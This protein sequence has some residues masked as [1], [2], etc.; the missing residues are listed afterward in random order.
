MSDEEMLDVALN[1][2]SEWDRLHE[3]CRDHTRA[4]ALA[5]LLAQHADA[6]SSAA[7]A[8]AHALVELHPDLRSRVRLPH[9]ASPP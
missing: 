6:A 2:E 5:R 1:R 3:L 9:R 7:K 8:W 4:E